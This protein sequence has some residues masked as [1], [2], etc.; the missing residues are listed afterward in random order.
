[1]NIELRNADREFTVK[2]IPV[3]EALPKCG[4]MVLVC[5]IDHRRSKVSKYNNECKASVRIDK[6]I[7]YDGVDFFWAKGNSPSV[8]AWMPIPEPP[9]I[10]ILK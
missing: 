3:T 2:W 9:V 6:L 8:M 4:E 1:M 5:S 10:K 7:S